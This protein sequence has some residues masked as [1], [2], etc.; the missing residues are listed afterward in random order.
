[1]GTREQNARLTAV[2]AASLDEAGDSEG[3]A[4]RAWWSRT[5]FYRL[6]RAL[7]EE[8]PGA[9]RRRLLL[10]RA[11]WQLGRTARSVTDIALDAQYG[12]LEAFTR[13]FRRAYGISPSLYRRLGPTWFHLPARSGVHFLCGSRSEG[14]NQMDLFDR[15]AGHDSWHTRR[16]LEHASRLTD[17]Q[18][19]RPI[20][21]TIALFPFCEADRNLRELLDRLVR[22]KELWALALAGRPFP[23]GEDGME[24]SDRSPAGMLARFDKA[25]AEFNAILRGVRDRGAWDDTFVD[26]LCE[27]AET[28]TFGGM[29]AHV[30]NF[31]IYRRLTAMAALR[32]AGVKDLGMGCPTE[33]E[34]EVHPWRQ[35]ETAVAR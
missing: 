34:A 15:F 5:H 7:V 3:L 30:I 6:F 18:L 25:D 16:L 4:R 31:N 10:E 29:F 19:D 27:P 11:A 2:V 35:P 1:V 14:G 28:F 32:N 33:Y 9:M 21:G 17:E 8:T 26:A 20:K 13:A 22:T 24:G 23:P 12:S